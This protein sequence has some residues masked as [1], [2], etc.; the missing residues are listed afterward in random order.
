MLEMEPGKAYKIITEEPSG[1]RI[2]YERD[3]EG[4]LSNVTYQTYCGENY[5][6]EKTQRLFEFYMRVKIISLEEI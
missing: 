5:D 4:V 3:A 2:E 6:A 1:E